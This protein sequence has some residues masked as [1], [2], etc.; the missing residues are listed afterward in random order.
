M[1]VIVEDSCLFSPPFFSFSLLCLFFSL[2]LQPVLKLGT[3]LSVT[4]TS[5]LILTVLTTSS[6]GA[7]S[8]ETLSLLL[9]KHLLLTQALS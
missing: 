6:Q 5:H 9:C 4:L 7:P 2:Y 1:K 3:A 8:P